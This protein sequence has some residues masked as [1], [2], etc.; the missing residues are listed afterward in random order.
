MELN[1]A[2]I[3]NNIEDV[4]RYLQDDK[5]I[6]KYNEFHRKTLIDNNLYYATD[7]NILYM[8]S[9]SHVN[10]E[11]FKLVVG[12]LFKFTYDV[13][14]VYQ[15]GSILSNLCRNRD[16]L[17][18]EILLKIGNIDIN[19]KIE[20]NSVLHDAAYLG[21]NDIIKILLTRPDIN[22]NAKN[23]HAITAL[24]ISCKRKHIGVFKTLLRVPCIDTN[25]VYSKAVSFNNIKCVRALYR[26]EKSQVDLTM[27]SKNG[28]KTFNFI[29]GKLV[30]QLVRIL[31]I[32]PID[33]IR[34]IATEY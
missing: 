4:T 11:I 25:D 6:N 13:N 2:I 33:I 5:I 12:S 32:L 9:Y 15:F 23:C 28:T 30:S 29:R 17:K 7:F 8:S 18:L 19:K 31:H 16:T 27:N 21:Y 1:R 22:V 24:M 34:K 3:N 20:G 14:T 10:I 26:H